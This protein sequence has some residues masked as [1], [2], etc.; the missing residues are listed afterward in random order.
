MMTKKSTQPPDVTYATSRL[1]VHAAELK[2]DCLVKTFGS[3]VAADSVS[4]TI[5]AGEFV[6]LL[7]PSGSG[8]STTLSMVA[9][10]ESPTSGRILLGDKDIT[11][12]ATHK[13][14]LGMVFQGYALFPHMTVFDNVAFPLKLRKVPAPEIQARV[15]GALGVVDLAHCADRRPSQLSG[16]QQQRVSL[17]R[18]FVHRPPILLMDEP[19]SALDKNLRMQMQVEMRRLHRD[20]GTTVLYVTHDQEEALA[21]SDRIVVMRAGRIE[22]VASPQEIYERPANEFVAGFLGEA[23]FVVL[24]EGQAAV[25]GSEIVTAVSLEGE[26]IRGVNSNDAANSGGPVRAVLRP[27]DAAVDPWLGVDNNRFT[28]IPRELVYVGGRIRCVVDFHGAGPGV[29][30]LRHDEAVRVSLGSPIV[31]N[32]PVSRTV[33]IGA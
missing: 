13:R 18:A 6:T 26:T 27:E 19:L 21:L 8:K 4:L 29:V 10:F 17:A 33:F 2:L 11:G 12:L 32:W 28:V 23:N 20:L 24:A 7:G 15:S 16:G 1:S 25:S 31:L 14:N 3:V 5:N 22:Q 30:W 9:G